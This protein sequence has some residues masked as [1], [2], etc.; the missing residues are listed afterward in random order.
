MVRVKPVSV[1]SSREG[2]CKTHWNCSCRCIVHVIYAETQLSGWNN[3]RPSLCPS[4]NVLIPHP[5]ATQTGRASAITHCVSSAFV[6][7]T[8][9]VG[10]HPG[11]CAD[12]RHL[13]P[14]CTSCWH[15]NW[16][17]EAHKPLNRL[18][19]EKS[20]GYLCLSWGQLAETWQYLVIT[21]L[22][23]TRERKCAQHSTLQTLPNCSWG[24]WWWAKAH[25]EIGYCYDSGQLM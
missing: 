6:G 20:Q 19:Q 12:T 7:D 23:Q 1:R 10:W 16:R 4:L 13:W 11:Q 2:W 21:L 24:L 3:H 5:R 22:V 17:Q 15:R 18:W 25:L 9:G 8:L 14:Q